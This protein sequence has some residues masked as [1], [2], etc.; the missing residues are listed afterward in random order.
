MGRMNIDHE[1]MGRM[2]VVKKVFKRT[3][4]YVGGTPAGRPY[5]SWTPTDIP[6]R[7]GWVVGFR[8]LNEGEIRPASGGYYGISDFVEY[9]PATFLTKN[10]VPC[11]LVAFWPTE[12]PVKVP[13]DGFRV[14]TKE[15]W[16]DHIVPY[17]SSSFGAGPDRHQH[18]QF[19]ADQMAEWPRDEKGRFRKWTSKT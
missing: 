3:S 14:Y 11:L 1:L 17:H 9:E 4:G 10:R 13:L 6:E 15:S 7:K 2:V 19:L 12:N 8:S 5:L 16:S 18:I